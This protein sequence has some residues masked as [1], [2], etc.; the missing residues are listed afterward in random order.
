MSELNNKITETLLLNQDKSLSEIVLLLKNILL[1]VNGLE[2]PEIQDV[3]LG[4]VNNRLADILEEL[5][6]KS[7]AEIQVEID[8]ILREKLRG[9]KGDPLTWDDLTVFQRNSLRG[10]KGDTPVA[11]VDFPIPQDGKDA[12]EEK[13]IEDVLGRIE[14]PTPTGDSPE[15]TRDKLE[16]LEGEER[17]DASAIKNLPKAS[18]FVNFIGRVKSFISLDDT[19]QDYQG[20]AGKVVTVNNTETGLEF[21]TNSTTDEQV[22]VSANDTTAGYLEDKLLGGS[23][24]TATKLNPGS[25]EDLELSVDST[26]ISDK[27]QVTGESGD[28]V[29][30][31]DATDGNLKKIDLADL[32][33]NVVVDTEANILASTEDAGVIG[34]GTDT[35]YIY[36]SKG[37][38]EW[39]KGAFRLQ[40]E[41]ANPNMGIEQESNRIGYGRTYVTDK[42]LHNIRVLGNV[43]NEV[44]ALRVDTTQSPVLFQ[45]YAE[46]GYNDILF[47]IDFR[48]ASE[49]EHTPLSKTI[50]VWSGN[51]NDRGLNTRP[52]ITQ[53][54]VSM[55]A[56]PPA[57]VIN[58]GTF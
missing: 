10:E 3:N 51:S 28:K 22:K 40:D 5:K 38:G 58:G 29:L 24:I 12:D 43:L 30:I 55:G 52:I 18:D 14:I 41:S 32:L 44:G 39:L 8:G 2:P 26:V 20:Q 57:L 34:Y 45:L 7:E 19:P 27:T 17:L 53:Y 4:E 1:E 11:G 56:Y 36:I 48:T 15:E 46:G 31:E 49:L 47:D 54:K 25:D 37:A 21:Q 6:K 23:G 16:S 13:I 9:E 33:S 50:D 42:T 35:E